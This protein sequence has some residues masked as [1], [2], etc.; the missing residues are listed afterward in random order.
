MDCSRISEEQAGRRQL[1]VSIEADRSVVDRCMDVWLDGRMSISCKKSM[2]VVV[3][4]CQ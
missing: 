3:L 2:Q 4:C 1:Q